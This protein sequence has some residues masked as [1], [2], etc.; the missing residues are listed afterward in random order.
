MA[1]KH[2]E[3]CERRYFPLSD[4][5]PDVELSACLTVG[6]SDRK[7]QQKRPPFG[8]LNTLTQRL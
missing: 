1:E 6:V 3:T 2:L 8:G 4:H 5:A 7:A